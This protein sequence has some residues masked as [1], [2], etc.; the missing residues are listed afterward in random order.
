MKPLTNLL[1]LVV[2]FL[3]PCQLIAQKCPDGRSFNKKGKTSELSIGAGA[4]Q[5]FGDLNVVNMSDRRIL[6][7]LHKDQIKAVISLGYRY[8]FSRFFNFK[9]NLLYTRLQASDKFNE[10]EAE[11]STT[12]FRSYRNLTVRTDL[13]ELSV[14]MEWNLIGF[15]PGDFKRVFS[16]YIFAGGGMIY[17][18][19]RAPY[20]KDYMSNVDANS[21]STASKKFD[22]PYDK[23]VRLQPLGTEGQGLPGYPDKYSLVQPVL[24][25]GLGCK[26]NISSS[27][28]MAFEVGHH[29]TFTDYLDDVS[30]VY[31][32]PNLFYQ[33]YDLEKA[34]MA[35]RLSVRSG[36]IDPAGD[37][38]YITG[39][40][41]QRG[42]PKYK[43]S[44]LISTISIGYKFSNGY[45][46]PRTSRRNK[47]DEAEEMLIPKKEDERSIPDAI[48]NY[49]EPRKS[50]KKN[51]K[52]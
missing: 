51:S 8:Y 7:E 18:D 31:P 30:T 47:T 13:L 48:Q 14:L 16:P 45:R 37:H 38:N 28:T 27:L 9:A 42:S 41:Q 33:H 20:N 50:M 40:G 2:I 46:P 35:A 36:E 12:W 44:Y 22:E 4:S 23:W 6:G 52:I 25:A 10:V 26:F 11:Y 29:F 1:V 19:P 24:I 39:T 32:D 17:F 34:Q 43:D 5:Y 21:T 15:E 3:I 49:K